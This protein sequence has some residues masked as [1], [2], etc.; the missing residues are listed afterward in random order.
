MLFLH[1]LAVAVPK[2]KQDKEPAN[3][4]GTVD[5]EAII[6]CDVSAIPDA[7][8]QWYMNGDPLDGKFLYV[9]C[10]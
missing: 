10:N 5:D 1:L 7:D 3:Y 8:I 2:F 6:N 9:V 4:N